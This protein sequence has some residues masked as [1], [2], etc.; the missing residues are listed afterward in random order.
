MSLFT[1][2][3]NPTQILRLEAAA[4]LCF[5]TFLYK[6]LIPTHQHSWKLFFSLLLLPD[7]FMVGYIKDTQIGASI[8]NI[9]HATILPIL[10]CAY[11][12]Y[13]GEKRCITY[14]LIHFSHIF[15]DRAAGFGL[16]LPTG[17]TNT[18]LGNF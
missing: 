12:L 9:G 14:G 5:S 6:Q 11:G 17:F 2:L 1:L 4:E 16:K 18:H 3:T 7:L 10:T 15:M 8:Y 13:Y